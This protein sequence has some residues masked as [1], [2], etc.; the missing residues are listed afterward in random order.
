MDP[1]LDFQAST[2]VQYGFAKI[3]TSGYRKAQSKAQ[4]SP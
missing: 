3:E 1:G 2:T 4:I